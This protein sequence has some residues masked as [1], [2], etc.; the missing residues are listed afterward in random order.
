M[1]QL[2]LKK[3][4]PTASPESKALKWAKKYAIRENMVLPIHTLARGVLMSQDHILLCR[5]PKKGWAYLPGGHVEPGEP[6]E[7]ALL[8]E[9][10]E[11][12]GIDGA[13]IG[14]YLGLFEYCFGVDSES[15]ACHSHEYNLLFS[16][17]DHGLE[18]Q[19]QPESLEPESVTF[20]WH[21]LKEL[22]S[23]ERLLP[24]MW[25]LIL[26]HWTQETASGQHYFSDTH[27]I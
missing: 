12:L 16:V 26:P 2:F 20:F 5:N 6:A 3:G 17:E 9:L 14:R 11:E 7:A 21:P 24:A 19:A 25:K 1:A 18:A 22:Y 27:S 8:R 10:H 15:D 13:R 23:C 4:T